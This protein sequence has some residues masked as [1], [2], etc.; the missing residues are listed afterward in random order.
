MASPVEAVPV[1]KAR[2]GLQDV[3]CFSSLQD[4]FAN[5]GNV[6]LGIA[7]FRSGGRTPMFPLYERKEID[8]IED[9]EVPH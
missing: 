8:S 4:K 6:Q 5:K 1:L 9:K 3:H 7:G 2:Q